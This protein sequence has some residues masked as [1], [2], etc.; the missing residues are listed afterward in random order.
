MIFL[1]ILGPAVFLTLFTM[2]LGN[3]F[4]KAGATK[5]EVMTPGLNLV[6][7]FK[8][9]DRKPFWLILMPIPYVNVILIIWM[10]S[11]IV[12]VFGRRGLLDQFLVIFFGAIYLPILSAKNDFEYEGRKEVKRPQIVEWADALLFA[13]VAA[14][15]IRTF[16]AEAYT[17][18]TS[19]ME[20]TLLVGDYLFVSKVHYGPRVPNTPLSFPFAHNTMPGSTAKSYSDAITFPYYR[21]PGFEGVERNDMVV[22]NYPM[23]NDR[24]V[25]KRE[26]YIKR[27]VAI[28]G[29]TLQL[30]K[31]VLYINGEAAFVPEKLQG[32]YVVQ[33]ED[34]Q[35]A[36]STMVK[37]FSRS[38]Q[39]PNIS[40]C[41]YF[42]NTK[43]LY[44]KYPQAKILGEDMNINLCDIFGFQGHSNVDMFRLPVNDQAKLDALEELSF[45]KNIQR[46]MSDSGYADVSCFPVGQRFFPKT[47]NQNTVN[48]FMKNIQWNVDN[49]GPLFVPQ[50]GATIELT[51]ENILFYHRV[52]SFYEG[53]DVQIDN[54]KVFINGE[55][56][57]S[58]TFKMNYYFM[59]GDNRHNSE[60]SRYWGFVPED[61]VV[62]KAWF[63][64]MSIDKFKTGFNSLRFDRFFTFVHNLN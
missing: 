30:K 24:P 26:N 22:F 25:D 64:W 11:E 55:E 5:A 46:S 21:L 31:S 57:T 62:G 42:L 17:I 34:G 9:L 45:V 1:L 63:I 56:A 47:S 19:S 52:I 48:Y 60:D 27:C 18:P 50:K 54:G 61:H 15:I 33:Y 20:G 6:T 23:D 39:N 58:Y 44:D 28:A 43:A 38:P 36:F 16:I 32:S 10:F 53:N 2:L 49:F 4:T 40:D 37:E 7:W 14:T 13:V 41:T 8:A 12:K 29:D 51:F 59:M 35:K 3:M